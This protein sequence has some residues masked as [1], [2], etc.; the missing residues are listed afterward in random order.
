MSTDEIRRDILSYTSVPGVDY[1]LIEHY[2]DR[3]IESAHQDVC[4]AV[5]E[6]LDFWTTMGDHLKAHGLEGWAHIWYGFRD[7][8]IRATKEFQ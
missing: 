7:R 1:L 2:L 6:E 5:S 3:L 4:D 8:I